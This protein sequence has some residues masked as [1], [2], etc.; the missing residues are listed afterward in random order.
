MQ[1]RADSVVVIDSTRVGK[2]LPIVEAW[3][4][5]SHV[6]HVITDCVMASVTVKVGDPIEQKFRAGVEG[7]F[8][9]VQNYWH[10]YLP[11]SNFRAGEAFY[12]VVA[13]DMEGNRHVLGE[14]VLRVYKS[15]FDDAS[16][17][18]GA[19]EAYDNAYVKFDNAW[20]AIRVSKD[21]GGALCFD[22]VGTTSH[23]ED[24]T[25]T[26]YAYCP[27][28]GLYHAIRVERDEVGELM[29]T[30]D[31]MGEEGEGAFA[32]GT[33]GFYHRIEAVEDGAGGLALQ[34]GEKQ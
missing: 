12:K 10:F 7:I 11:K 16:D 17:G 1:T 14:G 19:E 25:G 30:V 33:D 31:S 34:V 9:P 29:L 3:A 24:A 23:P 21:D 4:N 8:H 28:D 2:R 22:V 15:L 32:I 13:S 26:P 20:Y 27:K 18:D 5:S 6:M